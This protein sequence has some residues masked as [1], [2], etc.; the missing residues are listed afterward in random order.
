MTT[1]WGTSELPSVMKCLPLTENGIA[2]QEYLG[3]RTVGGLVE[4][5]TKDENH[6]WLNAN[7]F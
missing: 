1:T 2:I 5:F 4:Q 7:D 6:Q 3:N